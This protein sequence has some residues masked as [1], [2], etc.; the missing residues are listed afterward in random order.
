MVA[1]ESCDWC[2]RAGKE[3]YCRSHGERELEYENPILCNV[4]WLILSVPGEIED[5]WAEID[6]YEEAQEAFRSALA[7]RWKSRVQRGL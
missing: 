5:V 3:R 6:G 2:G 1:S 7:E 4:C